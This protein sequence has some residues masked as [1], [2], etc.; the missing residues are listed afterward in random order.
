[1]L[2]NLEENLKNLWE[3]MKS[4]K[5]YAPLVKRV[6]IEKE[7]GKQR[8]LGLPTFED[9]RVQRAAIMLL[10]AIYEPDFHDFSHGFRPK[11]STHHALH[12]VR[13]RWALLQK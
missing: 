11:H 10:N 5:Y 2:E 12:E 6:W 8:P 13:N 4:G 3:R 1:M 7:D 9:K